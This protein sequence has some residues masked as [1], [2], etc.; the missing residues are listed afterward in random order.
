[1]ATTTVRLDAAEELTLDEL[2]ASYG[3][4][5]GALRAGLRLLAVESQRRATL[6][7]FVAAWESESGAVT[8]ET[9]EAVRVRY[10]L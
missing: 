5:S 4:R 10:G 1:M 8:E 7:E 6:A 9:V 2:A 3:G